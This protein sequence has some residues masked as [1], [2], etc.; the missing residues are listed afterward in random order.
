MMMMTMTAMTMMRTVMMMMK[1]KER[2][3]GAVKLMMMMKTVKKIQ[4]GQMMRPT[5]HHPESAGRKEMD[6]HRPSSET[7]LA[8]AEKANQFVKRSIDLG[9]TPKNTLHILNLSFIQNTTLQ[10]HQSRNH[11]KSHDKRHS[12]LFFLYDH[13]CH[14]TS[15]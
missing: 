3:V 4:L 9:G 11:T 2:K 5:V 15:I 12:F 1:A 6:R 14:L 13:N 10:E 7:L 8:V